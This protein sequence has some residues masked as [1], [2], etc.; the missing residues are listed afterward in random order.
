MAACFAIDLLALILGLRRAR[1]LGVEPAQKS[2]VGS[3]AQY[4]GGAL[5]VFDKGL[6]G[7]QI[8][9][10]NTLIRTHFGL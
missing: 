10:L 5:F 2:L 3:E 6:T 7:A 1:S 8:T 9:S 4:N